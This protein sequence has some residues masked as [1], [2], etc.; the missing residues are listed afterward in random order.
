MKR[1][2]ILIYSLKSYVI[3]LAVVAYYAAFLAD[4]WVPKTINSGIYPGLGTA[5]TVNLFLLILFGL[6]HS[7]M[8]RQGFKKWVKNHIPE[9]AERSTY[10]LLTSVILGTV[11]FLWQ[12]M[13][14]VIYDLSGTTAEPVLYSLY[15]FGWFICLFSTFLIDHFD[16]FGLKQAWYNWKGRNDFQYRF[17]TPLFYKLVR[18][19]IY[20][21]WL[22]VHW[23]T[24]VL[25]IGHFL[26]ASV[27]TGYI[28]IA[29]IYEEKDLIDQFGETYHQYIQSTPKLIPFTGRNKQG[30]MR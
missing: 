27:I 14:Q 6:Q 29:L 1:L 4:V 23:F 5:L 21:G 10:I 19:P 20:T 15:G 24:P 12:P 3:G 25:T 11:C 16:L 13:P 8:A 18:H 17:K 28:Y 9:S 22:M 26:F 2:A 30:G 7:V